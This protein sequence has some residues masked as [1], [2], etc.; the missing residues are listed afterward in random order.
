MMKTPAEIMCDGILPCG[1][2]AERGD[3]RLIIDHCFE[4][5]WKTRSRE[6]ADKLNEIAAARG[7]AE[8][9]LIKLIQSGEYTSDETMSGLRSAELKEMM[10]TIHELHEQEETQRLYCQLVQEEEDAR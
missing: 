1:H 3:D 10:N 9:A 8:T 2:P 7:V 4:C 5:G 6:E